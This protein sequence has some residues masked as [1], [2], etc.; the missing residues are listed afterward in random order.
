[1]KSAGAPAAA[2]DNSDHVQRLQR[3]EADLQQLAS[4][5]GEVAGRFTALER[6]MVSTL[7]TYARSSDVKNTEIK[8]L[9]AI[10]ALKSDISA[11]LQPKFQVTNPPGAGRMA[12]EGARMQYYSVPSGAQQVSMGREILRS[13]YSNGNGG[14]QA[15]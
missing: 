3:L 4:F 2:V 8:L 10:L 15:R 12:N 9:D 11:P 1:M 7:K 14:T 6:D 5:S 13:G